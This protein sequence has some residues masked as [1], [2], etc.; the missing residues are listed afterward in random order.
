MADSIRLAEVGA[1]RRLTVRSCGRRSNLRPALKMLAQKRATTSRP[2]YSNGIGGIATNTSS[3]RRATSASR[4]ADSQARTNWATTAYSERESAEG[5]PSSSVV[6]D[7]RCSKLTRARLRALLTDSTVEASMS[8][9]SL[10]W[11]PRT[12]RKTSTAT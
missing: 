8:A 6:G 1:E 3:V 7:H 2:L 9:T 10:A 12:S 4:S 11:N 5:G